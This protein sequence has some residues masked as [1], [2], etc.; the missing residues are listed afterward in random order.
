[1]KCDTQITNPH[2]VKM[3]VAL[4]VWLLSQRGEESYPISVLTPYRA[5]VR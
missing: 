3:V 4:C 2:E 5:Q 1:M